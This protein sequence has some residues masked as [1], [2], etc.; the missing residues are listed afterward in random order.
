MHVLGLRTGQIIDLADVRLRVHEQR[1][2]H[3]RNV[4]RCDR[5]GLALAERQSDL[6]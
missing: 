1:G 3:T 2:D 6:I 5:R 4:F